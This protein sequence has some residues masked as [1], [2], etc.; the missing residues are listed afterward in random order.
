[1]EEDKEGSEAVTS[2]FGD[3]EIQLSGEVIVD[4]DQLRVRREKQ[5]TGYMR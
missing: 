2:E 1:M 3:L 5:S 4:E